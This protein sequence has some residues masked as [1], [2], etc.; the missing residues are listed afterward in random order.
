MVSVLLII[1]LSN[2]LIIGM[3]GRVQRHRI[4][5][6]TTIKAMLSWRNRHGVAVEA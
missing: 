3:V 6:A 4:A 2:P 5:K 1:C